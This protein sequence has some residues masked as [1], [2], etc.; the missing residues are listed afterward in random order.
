MCKYINT[1]DE[2]KASRRVSREVIASKVN[3]RVYISLAALTPPPPRAPAI[4]IRTFPAT[5]IGAK[6]SRS[7][8]TGE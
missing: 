6:G 7:A 4:F 8:R 3:I 1:H 5:G 2:V